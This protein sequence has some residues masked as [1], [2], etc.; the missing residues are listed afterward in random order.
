V[1]R[2]GVVLA[3][4]LG[5]MHGMQVM[6]VRDTGVVTGLLVIRSAMVL[7]GLAVMPGG[8]FVVFGGLVVMVGQLASVHDPVL[9]CGGRLAQIRI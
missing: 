4:F 6:A 5:V 8:G 2:L 3:G 1:V 9:L 7:R